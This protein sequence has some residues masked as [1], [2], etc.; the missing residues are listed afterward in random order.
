MNVGVNQKIAPIR[1]F[2]IIQPNSNERFS[3]AMEL[4][5]SLWGGIFCPIFQYYKELPAEF[6]S[7]FNVDISTEDFY[8]NTVNNYDPDV[9]IIDEDIDIELIKDLSGGRDVIA[10]DIFVSNIS[11]SE[12]STVTYINIAEHFRQNEFKYARNDNAK[13]SI[14]KINEN[15]LSNLIYQAL[16]HASLNILYLIC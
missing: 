3:K 14:P 11:G 16:I 5:F 7:E 9:I 12:N 4:A 8:R 13:F 1:Y 10:T 15:E 2:F 6:R